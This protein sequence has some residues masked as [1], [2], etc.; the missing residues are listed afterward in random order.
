MLKDTRQV[1]CLLSAAPAQ[2]QVDS[3]LSNLVNTQIEESRYA[4]ELLASS[5]RDMLTTR[6]SFN[7]IDQY[8]EKVQA[9]LP[10]TRSKFFIFLL[11]E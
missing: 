10:G 1:R 6:A 8:C 4:L 2:A 11:D 7:D 9:L 3:H 5:T